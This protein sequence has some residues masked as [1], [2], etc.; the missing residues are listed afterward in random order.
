[1]LD[2]LQ[3]AGLTKREAQVYLALLQKKE[4]VASEISSIVPVG[5]TKIYEIIPTLLS[6]GLCS[7]SLKNGKKVFRAVEPKIA[8]QNICLRQYESLHS[9]H[10]L[11]W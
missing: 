8:L 9:D 10:P 5:R 1:M 3:E 6:K 4:F 2:Q 7:E 11:Y